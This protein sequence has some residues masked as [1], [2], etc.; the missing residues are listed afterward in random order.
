MIISESNGRVG[1]LMPKA[2]KVEELAAH[3][4]R[5]TLDTARDL[6]L[7]MLVERHRRG[8][9]GVVHHQGDFGQIARRAQ[10]VRSA[11]QP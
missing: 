8:A 11:Q 7:L 9:V 3:R 5:L 4:A 2:T 10:L 6:D 1:L